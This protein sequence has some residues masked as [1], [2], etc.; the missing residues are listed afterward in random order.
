MTTTAT[1]ALTEVDAIFE[2]YHATGAAPGFA[3]GVVVDGELVHTGA[4]GSIR[5]E[6][7]TRPGPDTRYRIASMTKSF[8]AAAILRLR[9]D[10]A[11]RLDD[12]LSRWVPELDATALRT[13][14]DTPPV[15]IRSLLTMS[16][17]LPTDDPW[18]D[19]QLGLD[20]AAFLRFLEAGPEPAWP[21]GTHYEYSNTGYAILGVVVGRASGE[22][23]RRY[24]EGRFL[25]S[26]GLT[27]TTFDVDGI[28]PDEI[29]PGYVRRDG[30]CIEEPTAPDGAYA[31]MGGLFST[32]RDLGAWVSTLLA[33]S[34]PRDD[35]ET[36]PL[37]RSSLREMQQLHRAIPPELRWTRAGAPPVPFVSG[38]GY[39][40]FVILDAE[41]GRI[42]THSGGLPGYGSNMR[43]H[44][45]SGLGIVTVA[46]GRYAQPGLVCRDALNAL[47]D[48]GTRPVRRPRP[49]PSTSAARAAVERL[50][51]AWDDDLAQRT[52]AMNVPLDEPFDR[53]RAEIDRI[54]A[55]HGRLHPD[56]STPEASDSPAHLRWSLVG[57]R[58]GRV[59]V[60][61]QM[62]PERP[63]R[64]QSLEL[65]SV[66]EPSPGLAD[67]GRRIAAL[68]AEARPAWPDDLELDAAVDRA[69][70]ER[71]LRAADA[72][73]GPLTLGAVTACDGRRT[74]TWQLTGSHGAVALSIAVDPIDGTVRAV[75][76]VPAGLEMPSEAD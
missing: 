13:S 56:E 74:A 67:V 75:S 27:R 23:Y 60:E 51:G 76:L 16:A 4:H 54:R 71:D 5:A 3:Y 49:W 39:G 33:A 61:I 53:R 35:P 69:A 50:I 59:S 25:G 58:G 62:G 47:I 1:D 15:T 63:P 9:D 21:A 28:D 17:G 36:A 37:A 30:S 72:L 55:V 45:A 12:E 2:R 48:A 18:G 32:V 10:G 31:P 52:F 34:P 8:T 64:V 65:T 6:G 40:L 46:N 29:A 22:G 68:T 66:A 14:A 24:V 41:R 38:Y 44:P 43:W 70:L 57:E 11:L 26:L 42:V 73:F 20:P 19:R 7:E